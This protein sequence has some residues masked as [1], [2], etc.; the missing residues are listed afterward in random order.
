MR[1]DFGWLI[2]DPHLGKKFEAGVPPLR[3]GE[4]EREQMEQFKDE[5][6]TDAPMIVMV[7]DLFENPYVSHAVVKQTIDAVLSAAR[8]RPEVQF[9]FMAGNHDRPRKLT[10]SGAFD[11]FQRACNLRVD[12]LTV[13]T[14]PAIIKDVAFFPWEW[15][16]TAESQVPKEKYFNVKA[17][18]GHWDLASYGGDDSHLAPVVALRHA[19]GDVPL[20]SGHYHTPGVYPVE[21]VDVHCTGSMQPYSQ[22]EDPEGLIYV[23]M[24]LEELLEADPLS[25]ASRCLRVRLRPGETLP[26]DID[27]RSIIGQRVEAES[28]P[29]AGQTPALDRFDWSAI[30]SK[31]LEPLD[32]EVRG[33]IEERL[34]SHA[35]E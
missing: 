16:H 33:F 19:F 25:L 21:G 9:V 1:T 13:L 17:A 14:S 30:I 18:V 27:C 11:V 24:D 35:S 31:A 5:L 2:G 23:T 3:R 12:N 28:R 10:A 4:R 7:G 15:D 29:D 6:N 8:Q 20:Y 22:G 26:A 34:P 32:A